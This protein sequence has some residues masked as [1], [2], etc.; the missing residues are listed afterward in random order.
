MRSLFQI[1]PISVITLCITTLPFAQ[2][3]ESSASDTM[4]KPKSYTERYR[5]FYQNYRE[6]YKERYKPGNYR[7]YYNQIYQDNYDS[8]KNVDE[9]LGGRP[10]RYY[11]GPRRRYF[12]SSSHS[13][14]GNLSNESPFMENR[15][16]PDMLFDRNRRTSNLPTSPRAESQSSS[17]YELRPIPRPYNPFAAYPG[18]I[19]PH[20]VNPVTQAVNAPLIADGTEEIDRLPAGKVSQEQP[21]FPLG[22]ATPVS[23]IPPVADTPITQ[24]SISNETVHLSPAQIIYQRGIDSFARRNYLVA[25]QSFEKLVE[26]A[27][28]S[29]YAQFA[30]GISQFLSANYRI[31][32]DAIQRSIAL[33]EQKEIPLPPLWQLNINPS[34]I[35]FHFR[36]LGRYVEQNPNDPDAST[37]LRIL[38]LIEDSS[39]AR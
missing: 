15:T 11:D 27:P 4:E 28:D 34:D 19:P 26:M 2:D 36:K 16:L 18:L 39:S 29:L 20:L 24:S 30:Y 8:Y 6:N 14:R 23:P 9:I 3:S 12:E 21:S 37:L 32:L 33:A 17:L 31:S 22:G 10:L 5:D 35:R 7:Q 38:P 1:I 25:R 13:Q